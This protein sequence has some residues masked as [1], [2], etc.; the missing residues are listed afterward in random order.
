MTY[1]CPNIGVHYNYSTT[2][3]PKK[4][5]C[6]SYILFDYVRWSIDPSD[7]NYFLEYLSS[8]FDNK[9]VDTIKNRYYIGASNHWNGA[10]IFW[11]INFE[12][13]VKTGRIMLYNSKTGKRVKEPF[14][15]ITWYHVIEEIEC[16]YGSNRKFLLEQCF[17]GEHLL[18]LEPNKPVAIVESEKTAVIASVYYP[19]YI[20]LSAGGINGLTLEKC[21]VLK[22]RDVCLYP[23]LNAYNKWNEKMKTI[24]YLGNFTIS[25]LLEKIANPEEKGNGLDLADYLT[26]YPLELF[27]RDAENANNF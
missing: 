3:Q 25:D 17:F 23:D 1:S 21:Q 15:H 27:I 6:F 10:T 5:N 8:L 13:E 18:K 14:N 11:Q 19:E 9:S 2:K 22:G 4:D 12:S 24:S 20:W 26:K 7:K 16:P